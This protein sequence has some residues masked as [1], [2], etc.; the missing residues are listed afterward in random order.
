MT[1]TSSIDKFADRFPALVVPPD[2]GAFWISLAISPFRIL[3]LRCVRW[4]VDILPLA[5][6]AGDFVS[7]MKVDGRDRMRELEDEHVHYYHYCMNCRPGS[8]GSKIRRAKE[9]GDVTD[10]VG[11]FESFFSDFYRLIDC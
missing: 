10:V 2:D 8:I 7:R 4:S 11:S 6:L 5:E 1:G 3:G 9:I